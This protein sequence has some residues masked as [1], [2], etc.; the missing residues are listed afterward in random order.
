MEYPLNI[1]ES[2]S[3]PL[4]RQCSLIIVFSHGNCIS[5]PFILPFSKYSVY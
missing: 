2:V 1:T 5:E 3:V 4:H